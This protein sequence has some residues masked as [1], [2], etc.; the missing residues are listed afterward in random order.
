MKV[1][2]KADAA[3]AW[4]D[5]VGRGAG[6]GSRNVY[7][8]QKD[9]A[10]L[11]VKKMFWSWTVVMFVQHYE[12]TARACVPSLVRELRSYMLCSAAKKV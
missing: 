10:F 9:F 4:A 2:V 8:M 7:W 6:M 3:G 12:R 1:Q 11:R 5:A